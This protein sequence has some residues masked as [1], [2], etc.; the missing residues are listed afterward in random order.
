MDLSVPQLAIPSQPSSASNAIYTFRRPR[1]Q[2]FALPYTIMNYMFTKPSSGKAWKKLIM[3]CKY[4]FSK[5]P[6]FPVESLKSIA[7]NKWNA[8]G[9]VFDPTKSVAKLW[10]YKDI[11]VSFYTNAP[12]SLSSIIPKICKCDLRLIEIWRHT[13]TFNEYQFLTSSGKCESITLAFCDIKNDDGTYVAFEKLFENIPKVEDFHMHCSGNCFP[14]FKP[15]T[16]NKLADVTSNNGLKWLS[17]GGL[18]E[19]FDFSTTLDFLLKIKKSLNVSLQ[20]RNRVPLSN[21]YKENLETCIA[22][23]IATPPE[24]IPNITFPGFEE[25]TLYNDYKKLRGF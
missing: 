16:F 9:E 12:T 11:N 21:A 18:T 4:F 7:N 22:K 5:N 6:I 1:P 14:M 20:Y 24:R 10:L 8:D 15:D 25:S 23:I 3:T 13:L 17:L 19:D 2:L